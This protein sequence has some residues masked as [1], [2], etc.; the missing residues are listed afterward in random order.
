MYFMDCVNNNGINCMVCYN[1]CY[2]FCTILGHYIFY[3]YYAAV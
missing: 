1:I 3:S 2:C